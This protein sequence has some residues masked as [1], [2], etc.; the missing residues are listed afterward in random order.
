MTDEPEQTIAEGLRALSA[1]LS[2]DRVTLEEVLTHL[3]ERSTA[4]VLIMFSIPAIVPTPGVPAGM[5][6]GSAL[7]IVAVQMMSQ[8][9]HFQLPS[10]LA[11]RSIR[12]ST[13]RAFVSSAAKW[14]SRLETRA[15]PRWPVLTGKN[16]RK[17]AAPVVFLMGGLI[18]LPIPF[19]NVIPGLA[20]LL[21]ALGLARDDG[22]IVALG[23][24]TS[25]AAIASSAL[26]VFGGIWLIELLMHRALGN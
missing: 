23:L 16:S 26:L 15:R 8:A 7:A 13:I 10:W 21:L 3:G 24:T 2:S 17:G 5:I 4:L 9:P 19:G 25:I 6:F 1:Q 12:S 20:V 11:K 14:V 18:A 22:M